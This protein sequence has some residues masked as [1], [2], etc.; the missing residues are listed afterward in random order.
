MRQSDDNILTAVSRSFPNSSKSSLNHV[1]ISYQAE[2]QTRDFTVLTLER[3]ILSNAHALIVSLE[4]NDV[5]L[6]RIGYAI[7][8]VGL[9]V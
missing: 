1:L 6:G 5:S 9:T 4:L 8:I 3:W 7:K 2:I